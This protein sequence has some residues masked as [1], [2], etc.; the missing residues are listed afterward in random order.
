MGTQSR[1]TSSLDGELTRVSIPL[2]PLGAASA[3]NALHPR[4]TGQHVPAENGASPRHRPTRLVTG[5][6][7][8]GRQVEDGHD[9]MGVLVDVEVG[10]TGVSV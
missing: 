2:G 4:R 1:E 10:V 8:A 3:Q 7:G 6:V 9:L 5:V